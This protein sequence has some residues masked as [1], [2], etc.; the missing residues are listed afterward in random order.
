MLN[1]LTVSTLLKAVILSTALVVVI[2][3]SISAWN[4]WTR[5]QQANRIVAV[6]AASADVFKAMANIRSDRSTS[7][8]QLTS[9][10]QMDK[11]IETYIRGIRDELM[12]A[13]ARAIEILP[14]IDLPQRGTVVADLDRLNKALLAQQAEFW[15]EVAKPRASRRAALVKEY[16]ESEDGLMAIL[17]KLSPVLAASVNHQDAMIDQLLMIKQ[18]AWLLRVNAGESSLIVGNALNSGKI[19]PEVQLAFTKWVGGT[20]TAW[21]ATELAASGMQLPPALAA[22]MAETKSFYFDPQY[23]ATRD[24][25]IAAIAKGE[26][27]SMTAN[28]WSPYSVGRM[29]SAI[30]LADTALGAARDHST[31]QRAQALQSLL[32]QLVLLIAAILFTGAAMLAVSRRVITPLHRIRDAMLKVAGGDLTVDSGYLDRHDEI[33]ALAG[34]LETFKQ[35]AIDKLKIEAQERERNA[36]AAARQRAMETYVGEFEGVVR[37]SLGE[38]SEASGEMR[39]TSGDLSA[40][41]RQTNERVEIAGK[42]SNDASTSVESVAA[43]A[44]E[45]S[46]SINDISQQAAHAAG[47]ASRAV[48]QARET[49]STVQGLAQSAGRIGE[50]VGLINTIAAQTNLLALNATIEAARA[51][52][53]GRGF[54]VVASEVKSLASQTAKATEEISEQIADIQKVAGDAINAIQAIG[55]IIGEV[56]E[57][58]TAIAAAVQEQGAATQEIT[59]STQYAAQGTKNV[60]DNITGVKADADTAAGAAENV[61]QAS[62]TLETQSRQLGRQVSDFLGKIR[63]A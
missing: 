54:A 21:S 5:L 34:A 61:K 36:G 2:G 59:R 13:L 52:E 6:A 48:N 51:G 12:P 1:R 14:S 40:V 47:I 38:L 55:G 8:R 10:I 37:K 39:K 3:F 56:N 53:A 43:A 15:T 42:A 57:V 27:A 32:T 20:E 4:S 45:L 63:A 31:S 28:Q 35:Q 30:K 60:S 33:G 25:I 50:V 26:K 29:A 17:E 44:E 62:E 7:S 46:A 22:A 11:E 19:A 58:A 41:S 23:L 18:M 24:G 9:D 49:D 16:L